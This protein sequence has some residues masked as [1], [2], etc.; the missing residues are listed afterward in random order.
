MKQNTKDRRDGHT[1]LPE[2]FAT[3]VS[4]S[5]Q[6]VGLCRTARGV[7]PARYVMNTPNDFMT[8]GIPFLHSSSPC[9]TLSSKGF[10]ATINIS[11]ES[12]M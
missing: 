11:V 1:I 5:A 7:S 8:V 6:A 12:K 9:A 2:A 10:K 3:A 4:D